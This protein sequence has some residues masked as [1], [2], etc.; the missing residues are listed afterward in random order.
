[1]EKIGWIGLGAMGT[2]MAKNLEKAGFVLSVYNRSQ[3]KTFPFSDTATQVCKSVAELVSVSDIIFT[4]VSNDTA[5]EAVYNE[6]LESDSLKGKLFIDMSTISEKLSQDIALRIKDKEAS[7]LD[8]PVAGSTVPATQGTLVILTGGEK[9]DVER[10]RPYFEKLGKSIKYFG[11][12][13]KGIAAKLSINYLVALTYLGLS[14]A[15]LYAKSNGIMPEDIL[16]AINDSATGSGATKL[17][18]PMIIAEDYSPQF[19]L[20]L[21]LKDLKLAQESGMDMP[22][23]A[24]L[25][26]TY[27]NAKKNGLGELD[28]IS[29]IEFIKQRKP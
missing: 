2:P 5:G 11:A 14:E 26:D 3:E 24:T 4:M 22:L 10:A 23:T 18:S 16:D 1:M 13:G 17:K 28:V 25:V 15:V 19:A 29:V 8:A 9:T 12:N 7:F 21:M 27:S 20:E 6:I